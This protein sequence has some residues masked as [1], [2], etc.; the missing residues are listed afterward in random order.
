MKM[1][2]RYAFERDE[3]ESE[4]ARQ[5]HREHRDAI[6]GGYKSVRVTAHTH[7][8]LMKLK[9]KHENRGDWSLD[10]ILRALLLTEVE[11]LEPVCTKPRAR[12][13]V[14]KAIGRRGCAQNRTS[15]K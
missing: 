6:R 12:G 1:P 5:L 9:A 4:R 2:S 7:A 11:P 10:A 13:D 3:G 14:H 8:L 15:G